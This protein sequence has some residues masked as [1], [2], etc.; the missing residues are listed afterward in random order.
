[1][2]T[3]HLARLDKVR[4]ALVLTR[5]VIRPHLNQVTV[6]P[7][8]STVRGL[9]TELLLGRKNGLDHDSVANLDNVTT[10]PTALLGEQ[11]GFLLES[12]E[13]ELTEA[14]A[15]AYDLDLP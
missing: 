4:P 9:A 10:I 6:A 7:I 3:I 13:L 5:D 15:A 14:I 2:R 1:M 12:Q 11:I 8:S